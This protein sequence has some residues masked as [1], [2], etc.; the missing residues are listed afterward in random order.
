MK[1]SM[2]LVALVALVA[3]MS[4]R[5]VSAQSDVSQPAYRNVGVPLEKR[6]D[7]LVQRMTLDEK[8]SQMQNHSAAIPR[9][10]IPEY[11][12]WNEGLHGIARSGY[13]TVFPQA[14]GL[15]A[16]WDTD[17]LHEVASTIST[18]ARAKYNEAVRQNIHSIYYGLTIWSP[19]INIF[20]DPRW[21][22]GQETYGEDPY[23]TSRLGV[24]FVSGLQGDDPTYLKAVA[25]P[26]HFAVHSGPESER[27]RFNVN[28]SPFDKEDTYLPA[29]RATITES[30]ADSLMCAYNAV[31][32]VPACANKDLLEKTLRARWNFGGF[33]T[34]DCGAVSDFFTPIGHKYS[35][36]AA[37]ASAAALQAGTDTSC[38]TEY[39]ALSDAVKQQL[40]T[41]VD[42]DKAVKRL[43]LARFRLGLFDPPVRVPYAQIPFSEN[44]SEPHRRLALKVAEKSMVLLKNDNG[45]LPLRRNVPTIA[46]VGPNAASLAALEGNYNAVP[47]R[48]ILP[49]DGLKQ[50]LAGSK[51]LYAQGSPYA[52]GVSLPVPRT[53]LRPT[54]GSTEEGL[55]GEY[56]SNSNW[57]G[58]PALKRVDRQVDF[59]W[60]SASPAAGIP[61][62]E[63]SVRW[64]GIIAVPTPGDYSFDISFAHCY[65][66]FDRETYSVYLDGKELASHSTEESSPAHPSSNK[67][68]PYH[69]EDTRPHPIR[70]DY[71]HRAKLFGAG[72]TLN[73]QPPKDALLKDAADAAAQADVILAFV[74]LSPE[75]EGEEMPIRVEGFAGGDRTAIS[76]PQAQEALLHALGETGKPVVVVLMNGSALAAN[77]AHEHAAAVLEAWYP[78]E[79]GGQAIAET[80]SGKSNPGGRLPVTF[81]ASLDQLPPFGDYSMSK[82]TYRYFPGE[83]LYAFG[84]GLSYT[85]FRYSGLQLSSTNVK[86]GAPVEIKVTVQNTGRMPG[87]DVIEA[88]LTAPGKRP[89][90]ALKAFRRVT[91]APN[92][93]RTVSLTLDARQQSEVAEDGSRSVQPGEYTIAVGG[94]QPGRSAPHETGKFTVSGTLA[95]PN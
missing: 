20:R 87:D 1:K 9:L 48:P 58:K 61:S 27:H 30:K 76:L 92:D 80:L 51:I 94:S 28:P 90:H 78:G 69:F 5:V 37:H 32:G 46:V 67:P 19:N 50:E 55:S 62:A 47:S 24:A 6:V 29:F 82:R 85:T 68:F 71:A 53:A 4:R 18:E 65:P 49:L 33:V 95:L 7:D 83:P 23:L 45:T 39:G 44:D 40:V 88:Y 81:Y 93:T 31:D 89:A 56:F 25:T 52:D 12:W 15:A 17:L 2:L 73:W 77:W 72:V 63:F 35:A 16:T 3:F 11:D 91:L 57:S 84:Y 26:K 54:P 10:E 86:A 74:G 75:L 43:F 64:T 34:S 14:I 8:I 41:E 13:A 42:L 59:D 70:I 79:S 60:N 22:R 36:D 38:G 21:G 66:C